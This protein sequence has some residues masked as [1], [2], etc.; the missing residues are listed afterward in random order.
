MEHLE[1]EFGPWQAGHGRPAASAPVIAGVVGSGNMEV[2]IEPCPLQG[3][4]RVTLDTSIR[5]FAPTWEA[6]L[7]DFA[8]RERFPDVQLTI[9]D[10]G[11]T[12]AVVSL[13][14]SQASEQWRQG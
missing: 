3:R 4:M 10:G 2:L 5:G 12:P 7:T 14:L 11:A 8:E 6:V 1:F 13:R 9:N